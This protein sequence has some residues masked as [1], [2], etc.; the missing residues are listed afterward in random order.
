MALYTVVT[1]KISIKNGAGAETDILHMS[2]W[3]VELSKE[4]VESVSFGMDYKEKV[5]AIKDWSASADGDADFD[6]ESGQKILLDAFESGAELTGSFYLDEDTFLVGK[7]FV[8]SLSIS[9]AADGKAE[10][11]IS[12]AGSGAATFNVSG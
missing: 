9:H 6:T 5:P 1:G 12:L 3:S 4:I 2:S 7:C 10:V 8:E 11:S